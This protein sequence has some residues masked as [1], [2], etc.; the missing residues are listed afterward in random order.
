MKYRR[1]HTHNGVIYKPGDPFTGD[2][3]TG[4]FLYNRRVLEPDGGP[5]DLAITRD[6]SRR[7]AWGLGED[8]ATKPGV[9]PVHTGGGMYNVGTERIRGQD[10]AQ[11]RA[12]ALNT[13][14]DT[15]TAWATPGEKE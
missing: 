7:H 9:A 6:P 11:D 5:N 13:T 1:Q 2:I 10:A 14:D 15:S 12:D 8:A 3:N 4:R